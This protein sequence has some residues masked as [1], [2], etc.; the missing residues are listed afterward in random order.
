MGEVSLPASAR[1]SFA[2]RTHLWAVESDELDVPY[3]DRYRVQ[4]S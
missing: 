2:T 1:I 4:E 3:V